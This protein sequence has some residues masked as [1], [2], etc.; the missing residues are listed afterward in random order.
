L[1]WIPAST[2]VALNY[3]S[4]FLEDIKVFISAPDVIRKR[5]EVGLD[6]DSQEG[7]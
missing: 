5:T 6:A 2:T 7:N 4:S 3:F 1:P